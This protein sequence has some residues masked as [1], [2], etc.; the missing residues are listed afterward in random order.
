MVARLIDT[1][2]SRSSRQRD[3]RTRRDQC[4]G[5]MRESSWHDK[6]RPDR[7]GQLPY[8]GVRQINVAGIP[9]LALRV[10]FVGELSFELHSPSRRSVELWDALLEAGKPYDLIPH[11]LEALRLLRLEKGHIIIGQDTDFDSAPRNLGLEFAIK[12]EKK[13]FLGRDAITRN[14]ETPL[15]QRL[16]SLVFDGQAPQEGSALF[17][18]NLPVGHL[19]SAAHPRSWV[20]EW[21]WAGSAPEKMGS[22]PTVRSSSGETGH[23]VSEPFYDPEGLRVRA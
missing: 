20:T 2:G 7:R 22:R 8:M 17:V 13:W 6:Q 4:A 19:T 11:G 23:V 1:L 12:L 10:G 16:A 15:R 9:C 14:D 21:D 3:C 18:G 5:P